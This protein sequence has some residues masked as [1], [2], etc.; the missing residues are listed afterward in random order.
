[1]ETPM[2]KVLIATARTNH[3]NQDELM[4]R[5]HEAHK[6]FSSSYDCTVYTDKNAKGF[7]FAMNHCIAAA[8]KGDYD[9]L[10]L[11]GN[12]G[13]PTRGGWVEELIQAQ[14]ET[15]AW[16]VCPTAN[17]PD[18]KVYKQLELETRGAYTNYKMY[19]AICWFIPRETLLEIGFFDERFQGGCYEDND[20]CHRILLAGGTIV[21]TD[22]VWID[23]LL[24]Q[25]VGQMNVPL[26]MAANHQKFME[27]WK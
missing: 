24:S 9:Y 20:Y 21:R 14:K 10:C 17:N 11:I 19:P 7:A 5:F 6:K 12:D 25:T 18:P 23:H 26:L 15:E 3:P 8:I 22:R 1:M 13:I 4:K 16:I 2:A 27:K